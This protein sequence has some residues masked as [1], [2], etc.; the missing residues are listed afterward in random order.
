MPTPTPLNFDNQRTPLLQSLQKAIKAGNADE[1]AKALK[2]YDEN[3]EAMVKNV[4]EQCVNVTD[5]HVLAERGVRQLT[6]E[7]AKYY[8]AMIKSAM[9]P[10]QEVTDFSV[11]MP[12]T[13]FDD[14]MSG[15]T[16]DHKLL[17]AVNFQ[18]TTYLTEIVR[19]K[20]AKQTAVWGEITDEITKEIK[21][22]F[23][24]VSLTQAKLTAFFL[25]S[26][27]LIDLGPAY[28][29]LYVRTSLSESIA[30][31]LEA[32][33]VAGTGKNQPIGLTKDIHQGVA[34]TD[35]A[36]PDK[37]A[38]KITKITPKTYGA[39]VSQLAKD[40]NGKSKTFDHV[41]LLV[42]LN[43]YL[44]KVMPATTM[45]LIGGYARDVFPYPTNVIISDEVK[46][47]TAV[48]A[49]LK[50]YYLGVAMGN[51]GKIE[52]DDSYKF[53]EDQRTY[54]AKLY[55]TGMARDN[56]DSVVLD[57]SGLK[58]GAFPIESVTTTSTTS[59]S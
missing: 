4:Y 23:F 25:V 39:V 15:I 10:H 1:A 54:K 18:P 31:G 36:Y 12:R 51:Q 33:I 57:V 28:L 11:A 22:A 2:A 9:S 47:D 16:Q 14:V 21:G 19:N 3:V 13:I 49:V 6:S 41:D 55:A 37:T 20:D 56:T 53:L 7:E 48:L 24:K 34:V 17:Q 27:G 40:E 29:D 26:Q 38:V 44:T 42:N 59:G 45:T 8:Q 52:Y 50:N 32:A 5:K 46:D 30:V 43:T 35:G 58:E